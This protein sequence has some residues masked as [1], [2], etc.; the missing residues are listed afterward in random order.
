MKVPH[1]MIMPS[2]LPPIESLPALSHRERFVNK[3]GFRSIL[4]PPQVP[5]RRGSIVFEGDSKCCIC[6]PKGDLRSSRVCSDAPTIPPRRG[7]M[8]TPMPD[9]VADSVNPPRRPTRRASIL[10][11]KNYLSVDEKGFNPPLHIIYVPTN[12]GE[13]EEHDTVE[14]QRLP[15]SHVNSRSVGFFKS[16]VRPPKLPCRQR[17][18][19]AHAA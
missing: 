11:E 3:E 16:M 2:F 7:S 14:N 17:T 1:S 18:L 8:A 9:N 6:V 4:G 5:R 12:A 15:K 13:F 19:E 10:N